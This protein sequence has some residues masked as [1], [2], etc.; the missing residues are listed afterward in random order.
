MLPLKVLVSRLVIKYRMDYSSY[1]NGVAK[2]EL[3]S[4]DKLAGDFKIETV[5][6][7]HQGRKVATEDLEQFKECLKQMV[8]KKV[9][10]FFFGRREISIVERIS[11]RWRTWVIY[12]MDGREKNMM[13]SEGFYIKDVPGLLQYYEDYIEDGKL[14]NSD[15]WFAVSDGKAELAL[16]LY[17]SFTLDKQGNL[18]RELIYNCPEID[19]KFSKVAKAVRVIDEQTTMD[20]LFN[21][22]S[23]MIRS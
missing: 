5:E 14:V 9:T 23:L 18:I 6:F 1:L 7:I 17:D 10:D 22:W 16:E 13:C 21:Y 4:L 3:D 20:D 2:E 19:L 11:S 15:K 8:P 12:D